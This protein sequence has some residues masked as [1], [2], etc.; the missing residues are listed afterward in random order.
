MGPARSWEEPFRCPYRVPGIPTSHTYALAVPGVPLSRSQRRQLAELLEV[1]TVA[2]ELAARFADAGHELYLVG[3]TVRDALRGKAGVDLDFATD[4]TPADVVELA[5]GWAEAVWEI[6]VAFG[7][8]GLQKSGV[9][10]EVTTYRTEKYRADSRHPDV[11][12][13]DSIEVDLSRRDFT[14]NAM[15]LSLPDRELVDPFGGL[16]DL[17]KRVLRTPGRPE[18]SFDDDP[19]RMLRAFRFAAQLGFAIA[20]EVLDAIRA[21]AGRLAIVSAERV[22]DE[23]SK[24]LISDEPRRGL[25]PFVDSGLAEFVLPELP[26]LRL[27]LDP[28]HRH[29]DVYR[30]TLAVL[31]NVMQL[32]PSGP[33]LVLRMAALLH[34]IGKPKTRAFESGGRVTFHHHEVVG[35]QMARTRL[36]ALR[37]PRQVVDDVVRLIELHL[38]FHGYVEGEWTDA[39]V[40]RY[41]RDADD[42]LE[43]LHVLTRSDC[44]TRNRA[45]SASLARAYDEL[46]ARIERLA[47]E[48]DL[49]RIRP[50]LDGHEIMAVLGVRPGPLVGEAYRHLLEERIAHG[51]LGREA[52]IAELHRW[53]QSRGVTPNSHNE[54]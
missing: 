51:P 1:P 24:L 27:E 30:H 4:A 21:M 14:V 13:G 36:N 40:R 37:F 20:P 38:R 16:R 8:V 22:R 3:G 43:R 52:A 47:Q 32:E 44:T 19:L 33:D 35:A 28:I 31:D 45:K 49:A 7:T 50:D 34:D 54:P 53:A 39:A 48:E 29:K 12:F 6:G 5:G 25:E 42:L 2:D 46:E 9:R 10:L 15:A 11:E 23:L 26:R 18:E 17:G 41:V